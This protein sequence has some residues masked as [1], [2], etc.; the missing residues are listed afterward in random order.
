LNIE[1]W[2]PEKKYSFTAKIFQFNTSIQ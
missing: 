2:Q 1:I